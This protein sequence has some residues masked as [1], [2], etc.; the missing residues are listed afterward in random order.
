MPK[1]KAP[2]KV[3]VIRPLIDTGAHAIKSIHEIETACATSASF[4]ASPRCQDSLKAVSAHR[5]E[6]IKN[7]AEADGHRAALVTLAHH[8]IAILQSV[9][10]AVT[11][12]CSDVQ[13]VSQGDPTIAESMGL[14]TKANRVVVDQVEIPTGLHIARLKSGEDRVEFVES[15][16]G[17]MHEVEY[18]ISP[19]TETSW[20]PIYGGG[21]SRT[22]PPLIPG[23][24]YLVHV[25]ARAADGTPTGWSPTVAYVAPMK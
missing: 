20:L 18:S 19:V 5:D 25:R 24:N 12:L 9:D 14:T 8:E 4:Q 7:K 22:F 6:L 21:K 15:V 1:V 13:A 10:A 3:I 2:K 17:H 11:M 16:G 23:Q